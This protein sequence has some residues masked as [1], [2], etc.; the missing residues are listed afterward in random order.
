MKIQPIVTVLSLFI[1][2]STLLGSLYLTRDL[3][4][5]LRWKDA[6]KEVVVFFMAY[7]SDK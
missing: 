3:L 7:E 6:N 1:S 4:C 2:C 5:E